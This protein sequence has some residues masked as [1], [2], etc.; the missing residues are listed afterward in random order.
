M[1]TNHK[2][3]ISETQENKTQVASEQA[4]VQVAQASTTASDATADRVIDVAPGAR[5]DLSDVN[6]DGSSMTLIGD[7]LMLTLGDGTRILLKDFVTASQ[8]DTPP[9]FA[10][11]G[12]LQMAA[13]DMLATAA[14]QT[15][16]AAGGELPAGIAP[17]AGATGTLDDD[18]STVAPQAQGPI[19]PAG[20]P[21]GPLGP[22]SLSFT[23]P[24]VDLEVVFLEPDVAPA[25][26]PEEEEICP[27]ITCEQLFT[28]YMSTWDGP[29]SGRISVEDTPDG[30]EE[31]H[32]EIFEGTKGPDVMIGLGAEGFQAMIGHGDD[33]WMVST[34]EGLVNLAHGDTPQLWS[35]G[36]G[37]YP[38]TSADYYYGDYGEPGDD[39]IFG[40]DTSGGYEVLV[41]GGGNDYIDA[42][43]GHEL[44]VGDSM[45]VS[46]AK[47]DYGPQVAG[48]YG[49]DVF[50]IGRSYLHA[51]DHEESRSNNFNDVLFSGNG[52]AIMIGDVGATGLFFSGEGGQGGIYGEGIGFAEG[53]ALDAVATEGGSV[54]AFNDF[55][56]AEGPVFTEGSGDF[57]GLP[58]GGIGDK[59]GDDFGNVL[60]GDVGALGEVGF[61]N[62]YYGFGEGISLNAQVGAFFAEGA[63]GSSVTAFNDDLCGSDAN[64][65][66]VG[67][68]MQVGV[69]GLFGPGE[70]NQDDQQISLF[71]EG[72]AVNGA[73]VNAYNDTILGHGGDDHLV[74]DVLGFNL[75]EGSDIDLSVENRVSSF[76]FG[77]EEADGNDYDAYNDVMRPGEGNDLSVGDVHVWGYKQDIDLDIH[78]KSHNGLS[79][80]GNTFF[81]YNDRICDDEGED[82]LIGDVFAEGSNNETDLDIHNSASGTFAEGAMDPSASGNTFNAFNDV[83]HGGD[84]AP[85]EE[86]EE[87]DI[88]VLTKNASGG[89]IVG[90]V[91]IQE[92]NYKS[93]FKF[94][95]DVENTAYHSSTGGHYYNAVAGDA[96]NNTFTAFSDN[97]KG[98]E[99]EDYLIGDLMVTTYSGYGEGELEVTNEA[100]SSYYYS[101]GYYGE[102]G[103]ANNN[104]FNAFNDTIVGQDGWDKAVG[105]VYY[106]GNVDGGDQEW[107]YSEDGGLV[108]VT[109]NHATG[110]YGEGGEANNNTF[111]TFSDDID[112]G[113]GG[114]VAVGDLYFGGYGRGDL[115]LDVVNV[116]EGFSIWTDQYDFGGGSASNNTFNAF[117]DTI[118]GGIDDFEFPSKPTVT[119]AR[120]RFGSHD[121]LVGDALF[122]GG[123]YNIGNTPELELQIHNEA[124][125]DD[126]YGEYGA[127]GTADNNTFN[128]YNDTI[129]GG[130]ED[131]PD[132]P[133]IEETD[134]GPLDGYYFYETNTIVGDVMAEG[135]GDIDLEV[136]NHAD[137]IYHSYSDSQN[138]ASNNTFNAFNDTMTMGFGEGVMVGDVF[139]EGACGEGGLDIEL[140]AHNRA[141]YNGKA[142][143]NTF[144]VFNDTIT[145]HDR[146]DTLVGDVYVFGSK[147]HQLEMRLD[148]DTDRDG[149]GNVAS[150]DA[151]RTTFEGFNDT[152][153]G[154]DGNNLLIGDVYFDSHGNSCPAIVSLEALGTYGTVGEGD[155]EFSDTFLAW[156]DSIDGGAHEDEMVGD[157]YLDM[158]GFTS[159]RAGS[160]SESYDVA[161]GT[162]NLFNDTMNGFGEGDYM[163]GDFYLGGEGDMDIEVSGVGEFNMFND[164][165]DGGDEGDF[166]VGDGYI[167]EGTTG[168]IAVQIDSND[169]SDG[170]YKLF[171]DT[172]EGGDGDDEMYGDFYHEGK[173]DVGITV[174]LGEGVDNSDL[175]MFSDIL[176]GGDGDDDLYGQIGSDTLTGGDGADTFWF[177]EGDGSM[178]SAGDPGLSELDDI[179]ETGDVIT[180]FDLSEGDS[181]G[182]YDGLAVGDVSVTAD[183]SDT[184]IKVI[185]SGEILA[186]VLN[187]SVADVNAALFDTTIP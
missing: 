54:N 50:G 130:P 143:D 26:A 87:P 41:G 33:D 108:M 183:G 109:E 101:S 72:I 162:Y 177:A 30:G 161:D 2:S 147:L 111:N 153:D 107:P 9:T 56:K 112:I 35:T 154:R 178:P 146:D 10:F 131:G 139:A 113:N 92:F 48:P 182:L 90:D 155:D 119:E 62:Y 144:D 117:N 45:A 69:H 27:E 3:G 124:R 74:G 20:D 19:G 47:F 82:V 5:I 28:A 122:M 170:T 166:M 118:V 99:G 81:A 185:A 66:L 4:F 59:F 44:I 97:I 23:A 128:A 135:A 168:E 53:V 65:I 127:G 63:D 40:S 71:A 173:T 79:A 70:G 18:G 43:D 163:A 46:F 167:E 141:D 104:E 49:Y 152:I 126:Y 15:T 175:T 138:S 57:S 60:I 181:I 164:T 129:V 105:D 98:S 100:V 14:A 160:D 176:V 61:D 149:D 148:N 78:N 85:E 75:G 102:G 165:M 31:S 121:T 38:V 159:I 84:A 96:N 32:D 83:L 91:W 186:T 51:S 12:D 179:I 120:Y 115:D 68:V 174:E 25:L 134:N 21:L 58:F 114:G 93:K 34:G 171:S 89:T 110:S 24:D 132:L 55:I 136:H 6:L 29:V 169:S 94:D 142:T 157:L 64:D 125:G 11:S 73:S 1:S 158:D 133:E 151:S 76:R 13:G 52:H 116:A 184:V 140:V 17:A 36:E 16:P 156:S 7:G 67:D 88:E 8:S 103:E 180:D 145:G 39:V 106:D 123:Y 22:T 86:S 150:S 80:D 172:M 37:Y 187:T 137:S 95:F 77:G 42:R